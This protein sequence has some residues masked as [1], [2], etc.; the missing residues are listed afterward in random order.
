MLT[1]SQLARTES[2]LRANARPLEIAEWSYLSGKG[3]LAG[4]TAEL[5]RY[6]NPDGG[7]GHGLE[8]DMLT[9]DSSAVCSGEALLTAWEYG[10]D[11]GAD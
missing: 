11:L 9:P 7:F 3:P 6:Q 8:A 2:W 4:I 1:V 5:L 10:S